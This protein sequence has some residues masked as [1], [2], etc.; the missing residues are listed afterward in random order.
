[1]RFSVI[2][3][4]RNSADTLQ[5]T[6]SSLRQQIYQPYELIIADGRST[7]AT[8]AI[9]AE[10]GAQIVDNLVIHAAGG[11]NR[12]AAVAT[13]DWLAFTD[14]D[15]QLPPNWL[16]TAYKLVQA[17]SALIALAGPLRALPPLNEIEKVAGD[18]L[19]SG[20]LQFPTERLHLFER[21][22]RGAFITANVFYRRD[23]FSVLGGFDE[24]FANYAEDIDLFW[25]A[26]A[27]NPGLLLY[28]PQLYV[29]HRFPTTVCQLFWKWYQYGIASCHLQR[30]H[31]GRLRLDRAHYR[32]LAAAFADLATQPD[33]RPTNTARLAQIVGHLLGKYCG[34][35]LLGVVNL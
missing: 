28:E 35:A 20:V 22:L 29:E 3:P 26:I 14:S 18:A 19:L 27:V 2:V 11:R 4:T 30:R 10:F 32:R 17:D 33:K 25:R 1:M 8:R 9:A 6:L 15:C 24:R 21:S 7:D 31:L 34:S 5:M 23:I 12:G 16:D 13:G